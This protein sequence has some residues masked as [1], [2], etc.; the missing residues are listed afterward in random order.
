MH[1]ILRACTAT[2]ARVL[3]LISSIAA[4]R[5]VKLCEVVMGLEGVK[6]LCCLALPLRKRIH[7]LRCV[8]QLGWLLPQQND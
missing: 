4:A 2:S 7:R 6:A 5:R 1:Q 8:Q 3:A